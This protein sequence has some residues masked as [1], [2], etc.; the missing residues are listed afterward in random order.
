MKS[1]FPLLCSMHVYDPHGCRYD[2]E[3]TA[4][5]QYSGGQGMAMV[6]VIGSGNAGA[7]AAFF[8]AEK[9]IS[10]VMLYDVKEGLSTG[11]AL[12]LMEAAP[13][14]SYRTSIG[15]TDSLDEVL[16]CPLL[17]IA[18][19]T[20]RTPD[21]KREDLFEKN[22]EIVTELADK[23]REGE[24]NRNVIVVTEPVD[25]MTAILTRRSGLPREHVMGVGGILDSTRLRYALARDLDVSVDDVSA[26]VIGRHS[27]Q[28]VGLPNYATVSGVPVLNLMKK[29]HFEGLMAEVRGAGDFIVGLAK[30]SS[31]Y[32][33]PSAAVAE[34]ADALVR[35]TR[36]LM[37]VSIL[38]EGEYEVEGVAMSVPAVIGK[39]GVERVILPK[40]RDSE[41]ET[42]RASAQCIRDI[43]EKG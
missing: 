31:A 38:L 30:R 37:S 36:R 8:I 2:G 11:K 6:G 22:V 16:E 27:D 43:L 5:E 13:V 20:V 33:A 39:G 34:L 24:K 23:L 15:G 25:P 3:P 1:G 41:L 40:L 7:N 12:D 32:Y 9:R 10:D 28:M 21:M 18:A 19:G 42:I 35:D 17:V 14:R 4:S 26:L 29:D